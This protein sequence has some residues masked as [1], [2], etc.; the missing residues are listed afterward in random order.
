M[1]NVSAEQKVAK[2]K[3]KVEA[4]DKQFAESQTVERDLVTKFNTVMNE[5]RE[6]KAI[7]KNLYKEKE[8]AWA[9]V[10]QA[11]EELPKR[12]PGR[13]KAEETTPEGSG[14]ERDAAVQ[15]AA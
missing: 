3:A 6:R 4:I 8:V 9:E 5:L 10:R 7:T 12:S 14:V 15:T 11:R 1:P 2:A 13:P